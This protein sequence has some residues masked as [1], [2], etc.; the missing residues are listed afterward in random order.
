LAS[1]GVSYKCKMFIKLSP[2]LNRQLEWVRGNWGCW[3]VRHQHDLFL[4]VKKKYHHSFSGQ[5]TNK[6]V[7]LFL[8]KIFNL[9]LSVLCWAEKPGTNTLA[10]LH[11]ASEEEKEMLNKIFFLCH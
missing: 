4:K 6:L 11:G 10:Y 5:R 7:R 8:I 9:Q 3:T 1:T 2:D